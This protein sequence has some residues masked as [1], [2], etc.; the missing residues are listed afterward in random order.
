MRSTWRFAGTLVVLLLVAPSARARDG[1]GPLSPVALATAERLRD[2][3]IGGSGAIDLVRSLTTEVGPRLAGSPGDAAAVAWGLRTMTA[4]GLANVHSEPVKVPHWVRGE[5]RAAI[6]QPYPQPVAVLA[7]GGSVG[8]PAGGV[9]AEV[10]R[11]ESLAALDRL[12]AAQLRGR[13]VFFDVKTRRARDVEGYAEAVPV[14]GGGASAA[15]RKGAVAVVIRSIGTDHNRLPHTGGV[16]YADG[17]ARIPA[18]ALSIP[19]ADLLAAE[20]ATGKPVRLHLELGARELPEADSANV[21]GE[22]PGGSAGA[23]IVL[24]GCHLDSWDPGTGALDDAAGCAIVLE[25][26]RQL[27]ALPQPPRRTVRVVLFANEEHGLSGGRAYAAAHRDEAGRTVVAAEAD[28]GAGR[29]W[30]VYGPRGDAAAPAMA[31]IARLLAPLGIEHAA[32]RDDGEG[33]DLIPLRDLGVPTVSLVHDASDYFDYHHTANDTADK[34]DPKSLDQCV[35]AY[36]GL[37]AAVADSGMMFRAP[38]RR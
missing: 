13:I 9:E 1:A 19:D 2:Q 32:D 37:T 38:A 18:A 12:D 15:A 36:L 8:T 29:I 33:A 23:E 7:L 24:L 34:V 27:R 10:V 4:L 14:R 17:V 22:V 3:A 20:V 25:T 6:V 30:Q 28:L 21:V 11:V 26:A 5:E 16:R 35:A 31:A